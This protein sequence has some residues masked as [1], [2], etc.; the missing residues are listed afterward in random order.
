METR[1]VPSLLGIL[2]PAA[3]VLAA[4]VARLEAHVPHKAASHATHGTATHA[5][6]SH[7]TLQ[8]RHRPHP[9]VKHPSAHHVAAAGSHH[10]TSQQNNLF[11]NFFKNIF[12]GL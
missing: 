7:A 6:S 2:S 8:H 12:G 3:E 1:L 5:T 4:R 11:S 10:K 9:Q